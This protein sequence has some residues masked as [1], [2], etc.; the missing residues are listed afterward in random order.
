MRE[1]S[2]VDNWFFFT[3][4]GI[5]SDLD[6]SICGASLSHLEIVVVWESPILLM[7]LTVLLSSIHTFFVVHKELCHGS[8]FDFF[9]RHKVSDKKNATREMSAKIGHNIQI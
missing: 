4:L 6:R 2:K 5:V 7:S 1:S 9:K 8:V 3:R